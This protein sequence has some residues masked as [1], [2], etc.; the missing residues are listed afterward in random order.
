MWILAG[1]QDTFLVGLAVSNGGE[2]RFP[3]GI[4]QGTSLR[5]PNSP[6]PLSI[7]LSFGCPSELGGGSC[8]PSLGILTLLQK[9]LAL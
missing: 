4:H 2:P 1:F 3:S 9:D 8:V 6:P 7:S 5:D